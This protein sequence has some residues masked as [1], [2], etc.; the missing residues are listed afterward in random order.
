MEC[1]L[2][3]KSSLELWSHMAETNAAPTC[4]DRTLKSKKAAVG[5]AAKDVDFWL[6]RGS[7]FTEP[8][9]IAVGSPSER[10]RTLRCVSHIDRQLGNKGTVWGIA[11]KLATVSPAMCLAQFAGELPLA[12]LTELACALSGNYRF[13]SKPEDVVTSAVPLTSLREMRAFLHA[14]QQIRGASKALRAID[15][16][17]DHLGSPMRPFSIC[18]SACPA[19]LEATVFLSPLPTDRSCPS[20][21]MLT[22][23]P[24]A[25]FTQICS[26]PTNSSSLNTTASST[27]VHRSRQSMTPEGATTSS[28]SAIASWSPTAPSSP[29]PHCFLNSQT[30]SAVNLAREAVRR[31]N[32][33]EIAERSFANCF[34][35]PIR[36]RSSGD[37]F[38][39]FDKYASRQ[40]PRTNAS[41]YVSETWQVD[42]TSTPKWLIPLLSF[43]PFLG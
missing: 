37:K 4:Y 6:N 38:L 27:T 26:G 17:I 41:G 30:R 40:S 22:S 21:A 11:P 28:P 20:P 19:S 36:L 10:C 24:N 35:R 31:R 25:I 32:T 7:F 14:H 43:W 3:H 13:A 1:T 39:E 23:L 42:A 12:Q 15:L 8:L 9:H 18:F 33:A 29:P 2:A 16:A 5:V 34:L